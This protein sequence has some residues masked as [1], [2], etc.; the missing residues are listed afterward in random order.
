MTWSALREAKAIQLHGACSGRL[1][2]RERKDSGPVGV[3][4]REQALSS[5]E[6]R[7]DLVDANKG[8]KIRAK[9]VTDTQPDW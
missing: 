8:H 7:K 5:Y 4:D 3:G 2:R 9:R 6:F 1:R